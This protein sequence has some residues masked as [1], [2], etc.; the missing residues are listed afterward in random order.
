MPKLHLSPSVESLIGDASSLALPAVPPGICLMD[1]VERIME[2]L[3]EKV[4]KTIHCFE[5]RKQFIAEVNLLLYFDRKLDHTKNICT[6]F[7]Y[8]YLSS[9]SHIMAVIY[10][11]VIL[12][13]LM[14]NYIIIIV[15]FFNVSEA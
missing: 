4:K 11:C 6:F 13:Q 12:R 8:I 2:L 15:I 5:T 9:Q 3:E 1:Y 7:L 10:W 14:I